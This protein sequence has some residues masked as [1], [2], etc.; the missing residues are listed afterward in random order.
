MEMGEHKLNEHV[1]MN[2][3]GKTPFQFVLNTFLEPVDE[4][5]CK[6]KLVFDADL[7]PMLAMMASRPLQN[8]VEMLADKLN[9][10][11]SNY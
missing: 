10:V 7:N 11:M 6:V 8:F 1:V 2:S 4:Q 5:Q 9:E 3:A